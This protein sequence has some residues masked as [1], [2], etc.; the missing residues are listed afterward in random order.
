MNSAQNHSRPSASGNKRM[1]FQL[2]SGFLKSQ[3]R[4]FL[5]SGLFQ[6][7][8]LLFVASFFLLGQA[9]AFAIADANDGTGIDTCA[10]MTVKEIIGNCS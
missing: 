10:E 7:A 6:Q 9:P 2:I 1:G 4:S 5:R 8:F 3:D